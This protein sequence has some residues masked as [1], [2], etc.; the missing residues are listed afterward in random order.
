MQVDIKENIKRKK[1]SSHDFSIQCNNMILY[2]CSEKTGALRFDIYQKRK[3]M[4]DN[5]DLNFMLSSILL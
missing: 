4:W 2:N 1:K 5:D 3:K